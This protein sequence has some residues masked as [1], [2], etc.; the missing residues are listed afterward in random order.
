M[1]QRDVDYD[2]GEVAKAMFDDIHVLDLVTFYL[3]EYK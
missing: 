1:L 3:K 2:L